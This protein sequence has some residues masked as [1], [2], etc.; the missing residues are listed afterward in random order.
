MDKLDKLFFFMLYFDFSTPVLK[1]YS[2]SE[3]CNVVKYVFRIIFVA[4]LL[5]K[6]YYLF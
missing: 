6:Y 3:H 5:Q 1:T 2:L 4:V